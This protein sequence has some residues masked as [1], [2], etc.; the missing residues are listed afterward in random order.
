MQKY[1]M[2]GITCMALLMIMPLA[3]AENDTIMGKG[4]WRSEDKQGK[5]GFFIIKENGEVKRVFFKFLGESNWIGVNLDKWTENGG[6]VMNN[7]GDIAMIVL[8]NGEGEL[9]LH[10]GH[11][12]EEYEFTY[13]ITEMQL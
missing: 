9:H 3:Y 6:N 2:L 5:V 8:E 10:S 1:K 11:H 13:T 4:N 12:D 7:N